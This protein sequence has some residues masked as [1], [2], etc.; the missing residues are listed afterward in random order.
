MPACPDWWRGTDAGREGRVFIGF[1]IIFFSE[2][3][4]APRSLY[5]IDFTP[6]LL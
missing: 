5:Y 3:S 6:C 1:D 2:K 4:R